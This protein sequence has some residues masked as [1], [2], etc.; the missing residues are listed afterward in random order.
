MTTT[1][2]LFWV[3][4]DTKKG[5]EIVTNQPKTKFVREPFETLRQAQLFIANE[6][7]MS[8]FN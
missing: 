4:G 8:V 6:Y 5:F 1:K 7:S 3:K 2:T